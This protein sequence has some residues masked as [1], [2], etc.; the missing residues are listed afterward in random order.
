MVSIF[1]L[2]VPMTNNFFETGQ[3]QIFL[4]PKNFNPIN[5]YFY[6]LNQLL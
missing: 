5:L 1:L 2:Y 3:E 6:F 4:L